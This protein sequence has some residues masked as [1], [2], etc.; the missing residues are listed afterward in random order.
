MIGIPGRIESKL[1]GFIYAMGGAALGF[2]VIG[3]AYLAAISDIEDNNSRIRKHTKKY[4]V[5]V[6]DK[7]NQVIALANGNSRGYINKYN[8]VMIL[9]DKNRDG[10]TAREEWQD[11]YRKLDLGFDENSDPRKDLSYGNLEKYLSDF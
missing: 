8:Q 4:Q 9:A 2:C 7:Y 6:T 1:E 3:M 10:I 11:I 5:T